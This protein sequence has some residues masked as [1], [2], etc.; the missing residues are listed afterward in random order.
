MGKIKC[1]KAM[2]QTCRELAKF[3]HKSNNEVPRYKIIKSR[4]VSDGY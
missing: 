3:K 2:L 4:E 1:P